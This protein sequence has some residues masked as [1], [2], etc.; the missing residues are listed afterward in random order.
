MDFKAIEKKWI[1]KWSKKPIKF[2]EENL[3]K[4]YVIDTPPPFTSGELHMGHVLSY[5]YIDFAARFKRKRGY[6]VFYPQGWDCQGFPTE[7]KVR[8]KFPELAEK[9]RKKFKEKCAEFTEENISKMKEQMKLLGFSPDWKYE[10]KTM[11]KQYH[12]IVQYSLIKMFE[13]G[14][15]YE[16]RHPTYYC[17]KCKSALAKAECEE[18]ERTTKLNY[19]YFMREDG[20][21]VKI[22]TTR[23]EY[24]HACVAVAVNPEDDRYKE[25]IGK[26]LITPI[27]EKKV[28]VIPDLEVDMEFGTGAVM[29]CTFGDKQ[30]VVWVY[31]HKLPVIDAINKEG[32]LINAGKYN[33][34]SL[35]EARKE[36]IKELKEKKL[37]EKEEVLKQV[38]KIHDRCKTPVELLSSTQWFIKIKEHKKEI[39]EAAKKMKWI[40]SFSIIYL[41]DWADALEWDWVI[42]RQNVF[43]TPLPFWKCN[44]CGKIK[45]PALDQ[46]PVDPALENGGKCD[47]CGGEFVG[48]KS[49]CDCWVDSSIT[50]LIITRWKEN[51]NFFKKAYPVTLRPQGAEII[52]TWAFY[53]IFR[54]LMLTGVPPF[55]ELLI[56]GNVLGPDGKKMSKSLKNYEDPK[57]LLEKF[58]ADALREWAA[59]SG[60]FAKD[61]PFSYKDINFGAAFCNKVYNASRF[62]KKA[63][64][65]YEEVSKRQKLRVI[66]IAILSKLHK[67]TAEVTRDM[68]HYNY[69]D[70]MNK[71]HLFFWNDFCD[72]YLEAVKYR[73]YG[74]VE[75]WSKLAAQFTLMEI[76]RNILNML[77]VFI[78]FTASES[79]EMLFKR[80]VEDEKWPEVKE[81][82]LNDEA[83][84]IYAEFKTILSEIRKFKAAHSLSLKED[85]AEVEI[86]TTVGEIEKIREEIEQ[87]GRIKKLV[88]K[89]GEELEV[90]IKRV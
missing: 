58:P 87:T 69:Y 8:A 74:K 37:F 44:K 80:D 25:L 81:D 40:P 23:P 46:L 33:G 32:K 30:D 49:V 24:L 35:K 54:T 29:I 72:Y 38:V 47:E 62:V 55:K 77:S 9:D 78:P 17:P 16:G 15:I 27:F 67:A 50:P 18:V 88:F 57:I 68:E 42:S 36:I 85:I 5:A 89:K 45:L 65:G 82:Y 64:E 48:E 12:K 4:L 90:N 10:Y 70:A 76:M 71:M 41:N 13:K 56:N 83:E 20:K 60:A 3:E 52:R 39:K 14:M 21:K 28:E 79:Y 73:V 63:V 66:D 7:V 31:R 22:A 34:L 11:D 61:R 59:L 26:K 51:E 53:T 75:K 86:H 84:K 43:G 1:E 19:L 6:N 2:S